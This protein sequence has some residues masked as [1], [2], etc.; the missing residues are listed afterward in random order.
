M[1]VDPRYSPSGRRPM[2]PLALVGII[3]AIICA[4]GMLTVFGFIIYVIGTCG[5]AFH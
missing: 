2:S 3:F 1:P 4:V 5:G